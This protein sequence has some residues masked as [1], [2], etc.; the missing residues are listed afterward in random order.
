MHYVTSDLHG[1]GA[2][3]DAIKNRILPTDTLF[4]LGDA[5]D[6]GPDG[7][8]IMQEMIADPRVVYIKGN[9][10]QFAEDFLRQAIKTDLLT[11]VSNNVI[12][13]WEQ[14]GGS[15]TLQDIWG[16]LSREEQAQLYLQLR[17]LPQRQTIILNDT[18]FLLSHAGYTPRYLERDLADDKQ[19]LLWNR[20]HF[21][22]SWNEAIDGENVI[23][24]H[25]HTPVM[26][27][28]KIRDMVYFS[29]HGIDMENIEPLVYADGHKIDLDL[30]SAFTNKAALYC[31][32]RK[33]WEIIDIN[34]D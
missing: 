21:S 24:L 23:S 1:N 14:N 25:G 30:C 7:L 32:E 6:R 10:E 18:K 34:N 26:Y 31:L 12:N 8:R 16:D 9:H 4:F 11:D 17:G 20:E 15:H 28:H 2:L 22:E 29:H 27:L 13:I 3:W 19:V 5:I 33:N